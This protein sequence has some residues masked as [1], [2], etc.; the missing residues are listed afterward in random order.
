MLKRLFHRTFCCSSTGRL[1]VIEKVRALM[2]GKMDMI[3]TKQDDTIA[4]IKGEGEKTRSVLKGTL[5]EEIAWVK[6][7]IIGLKATLNKVKQKVGVD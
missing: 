5:E 4:V 2:L 1:A 3:I 6:D 7:E